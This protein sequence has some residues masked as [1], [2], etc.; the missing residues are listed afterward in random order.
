MKAPVNYI[1]GVTDMLSMSKNYCEANEVYIKKI[2]EASELLLENI[3]K[4]VDV[5]RI[6]AG[7]IK[8]LFERI[9]IK[10]LIEEIINELAVFI[11]EK[12]HEL[13]VNFDEVVHHYVFIDKMR[14]K[15]VIKNILLNA[16][17]YTDNNG[18]IR[19]KVVESRQKFGEIYI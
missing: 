9:S 3:N 13:S 11:K 4:I 8:F 6:E 2:R 10:E 18:N 17:Q 7:D 5:S 12:K 1:M 19:I 14:L 16:V 15:Q